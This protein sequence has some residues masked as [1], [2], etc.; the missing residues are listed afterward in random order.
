MRLLRRLAVTTA[1]SAVVVGMGPAMGGAA[2]ENPPLFRD[3]A[4][5]PSTPPPAA[6]RIV[7]SRYV[8][9]DF[10][11]LGGAQ[12]TPATAPSSVVLNLFPDATFTAQRDSVQP[13]PAGGG[14]IWTGHLQG[15]PNS[16][17]TLV[18]EDGVLVGNVEADG[19]YYE[20]RYAG[21]G[22][23]TVAETTPR[24]FGPD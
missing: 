7:R 21:D 9:V 10:D 2:P 13:T 3:V 23:H 22:L 19:R 17:V 6:P 11:A 12:P 18:A 4:A 8:A 20:V 16:A 15:V 1:L 14:I 24:A 5:P